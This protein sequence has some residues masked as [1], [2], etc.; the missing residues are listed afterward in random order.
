M[1]T[2][3]SPSTV[4][5]WL[6]LHPISFSYALR[7]KWIIYC[8]QLAETQKLSSGKIVYHEYSR[9][10]DGGS[11]TQWAPAA[12]AGESTYAPTPTISEVVPPGEPTAV[13]A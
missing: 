12:I 11:T 4:G 8:Q 1:H 6:D 9:P 3:R 2:P 5:S 13:N 10:S 7:F